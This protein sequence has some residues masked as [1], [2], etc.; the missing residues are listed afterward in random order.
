MFFYPSL[1]H[2]HTFGHPAKSNFTIDALQE[3]LARHYSILRQQPYLVYKVSDM[4]HLW[5]ID[6]APCVAKLWP[7]HSRRS[8]IALARGRKF[9]TEKKKKENFIPIKCLNVSRKSDLIFPKLSVLHV[10]TC[11]KKKWYKMLFI[12]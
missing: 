6:A 7:C 5:Y 10:H 2:G 9:L 12:D 1:P 8:L 4:H 3:Q 11:T